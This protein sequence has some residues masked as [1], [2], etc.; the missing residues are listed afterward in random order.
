VAVV[1]A[2]GQLAFDACWRVLAR[3]GC[4]IK[5]RPAFAHGA[6]HRVSADGAMPAITVLA[7]F[8]PSQQNTFTGRLTPEMLDAV[9]GR[10]RALIGE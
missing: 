2:L 7:S 10:A 3:R 6:E 9:F 4:G 1:V 5:P 8:H